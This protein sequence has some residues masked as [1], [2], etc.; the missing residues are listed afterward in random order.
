LRG[1]EIDLSAPL[2]PDI[3]NF[4]IRACVTFAPGGTVFYYK[5]LKLSGFSLISPLMADSRIFNSVILSLGNAPAGFE[6]LNARGAASAVQSGI[7]R[8]TGRMYI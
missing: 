8:G 3:G 1:W 4:L 2:C 6:A 5:P 7:I